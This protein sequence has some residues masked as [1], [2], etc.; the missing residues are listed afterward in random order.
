M[1]FEGTGRFEVIGRLGAGRMGVVY[2]VFDR[3]RNARVALK[4]LRTPSADAL[5]RFK[6]EFRAL[7]VPP[8]PNLVMPDE[9]VEDGGQWLMTMELVRGVDVLAYVRPDT[10]AVFDSEADAPTFRLRRPW[11]PDPAI[12]GAPSGYDEARLREALRQ[13]AEAVAALHRAGKVHCDIKPANTCVTE[14]GRLVL[15]DFGMVADIAGTPRAPAGTA[16]SDWRAVGVLLHQML[17]GRLPGDAEP[18]GPADLVA[19]CAALLGH[20][21]PREAEILERLGAAA[22]ANPAPTATPFVGRADELAVLHA[23]FRRVR[24]GG[25]EAV[26]VEGESGLGKTSLVRQF[27]SRLGGDALVLAGRCHPR[28]SVP[29]KAI[30][31][32][33]DELAAH[34]AGLDRNALAAAL[35]PRAALLAQVFPVLRRVDGIARTRAATEPPDRR[36]LRATLFATMRELLRRLGVARPVV[37]AI[38]DL[39]WTDGDSLAMLREVMR[40]P[41]PPRLLLV[42][43]VRPDAEA[44]TLD[45]PVPVRRL[46]LAGLG[47]GDAAALADQLIAE[48]GGGGSAAALAAEAR[49]HPLFLAELVRHV[50]AHPTAARA[51]LHLEEALRR[52]IRELAPE[53]RRLL[54]I[55]AIAG[56]PVPQRVATLAAEARDPAATARWLGELASAHLIRL[57]GP[58]THDPVEPYHD[59]VRAAVL[60]VLAPEVARICHRRLAIAFDHEAGADPETRAVHW[61]GAGEPAVAAGHAFDAA[62]EAAELLAFDRAARLYRLAIELRPP[63]GDA[64]VALSTALGEA[65]RCAGRGAE[66]AAA[67]LDAASAAAGPAAVELRGRAAAQCLRAGHIDEGLKILDEVLPQIGLRRPATP[68]GAL[69]ALIWQRARLRLRGLGYRERAEADLPVATLSRIDTCTGASIG[70]GMVDAVRGA[71]FQTRGLIH[72]LDAGEPYRVCRA[73]ATEVPYR[74]AGGASA[75]A[76]TEKLLAMAAA[77]AQRIGDPRA[78]GFVKLAS[79][80]YGLLEG[81]FGDCQRDGEAA[82]PILRDE[83]A[84]MTW[85]LF[86]A[87]YYPIVAMFWTGELREIGR[88]LPALRADADA[89]GDRFAGSVLRAGLVVIDAL[90]RDEADRGEA[91]AAWVGER[92]DASFQFQHY[93]GALNAAYVELYRGRPAAALAAFDACWEPARKAMVFRIQYLHVEALWMRARCVVATAAV[94]PPDE[95]APLLRRAADDARRLAKLGAGWAQP[96]AAAIRAAIAHLG[97]GDATALL[98]AADAGFTA[99]DQRLHAAACRRWLGVLRGDAAMVAAADA[100]FTAQAVVVPARLAAV[101][102]PGFDGSPA[103]RELGEAR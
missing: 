43:T 49:G 34:L 86:N 63:A 30:D 35:P 75:H 20:D 2:E 32:I 3:E 83:C 7:Q 23:A 11:G 54:E 4:L 60:A 40:E 95:R 66:A 36:E 87:R 12:A 61:L 13:L 50:A 85:E 58:R 100:A 9:L 69:V 99:H 51:D 65:L 26:L 44:P 45:L 98:A 18:A 94:A 92:L 46:A 79:A 88:R 72:A 62:R 5:L 48:L 82:E 6:D 93:W 25:C 53:P 56:A 89:H 67:F 76:D 64:K 21:P 47:P 42:A 14:A 74:A 97:G 39:Q 22:P 28:E 17:T 33:V 70:L 71:Y 38:D 91:D 59:R 77:L 73:L 81:R 1:E 15:L 10:P 52:R 24:A 68:R 103:R 78:R 37:L 41:D 84:G 55:L 29:Y 57:S 27:A 16:A 96:M 8:H 101:F 90:A 80:I 31:G 19:L 102:A